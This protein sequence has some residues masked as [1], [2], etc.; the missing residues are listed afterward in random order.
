MRRGIKTNVLNRVNANRQRLE[1]AQQREERE[2]ET[3]KLLNQPK[4]EQ[5][6]P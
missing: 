3:I 4:K 5:T 6:K 2:R 1:Q